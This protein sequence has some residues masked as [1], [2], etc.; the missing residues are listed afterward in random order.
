MTQS[1]YTK[2]IECLAMDTDFDRIE[3]INMLKEMV[4]ESEK[5]KFSPK[6]DL[7]GGG[8]GH[9]SYIR[10]ATPPSRIGNAG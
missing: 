1:E 7:G 6:I 2:I 9:G 10:D 8:S 4:E 5:A 3:F